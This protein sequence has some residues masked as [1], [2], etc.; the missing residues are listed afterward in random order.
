MREAANSTMSF[1]R[2]LR[3]LRAECSKQAIQLVEVEKEV[4]MLRCELQVQKDLVSCEPYATGSRSLPGRT[5][6]EP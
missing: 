6:N 3:R 5:E 2:E 1:E 4:S